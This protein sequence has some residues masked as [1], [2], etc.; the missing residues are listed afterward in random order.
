MEL[1][2]FGFKTKILDFNPNANPIQALQAC[3]YLIL[4]FYQIQAH[5]PRDVKALYQGSGFRHRFTYQS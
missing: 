5:K 3:I 1:I 4:V 2:K